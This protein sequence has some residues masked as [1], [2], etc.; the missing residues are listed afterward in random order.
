MGDFSELNE[1]LMPVMV[2]V[3]RDRII[4][5]CQNL[6]ICGNAQVQPDMDRI[7][8]MSNDGEAGDV[9]D[10]ITSVLF[11]HLYTFTMELGF[12]WLEDVDWTSDFNLLSDVL[13]GIMLVDG[14]EDYGDLTRVLNDEL[15]STE[16]KMADLLSQLLAKDMSDLLNRVQFIDESALVGI[17]TALSTPF[18]PLADETQVLDYVK[19]RLKKYHDRL[20][21]GF[22]YRHVAVGGALGVTLDSLLALY[23]DNLAALVDYD[24]TI[25]TGELIGLVLISDTLDDVVQ[26]EVRKQLDS[27]VDDPLRL[28]DLG[29]IITGFFA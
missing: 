19:D 20:Y 26:D 28:N 14:L 22:A 5:A 23:N 6:A 15:M 10:D 11:D 29:A 25:L 4:E 27:Y 18:V 7:L 3:R 24:L 2:D 8:M 12:A 21:K 16:E 9:I 13:K 1:Y 17:A